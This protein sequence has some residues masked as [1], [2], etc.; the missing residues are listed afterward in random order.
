MAWFTGSL[1]SGREGAVKSSL[2]LTAVDHSKGNASGTRRIACIHSLLDAGMLPPLTV[3]PGPRATGDTII[4][5]NGS[6]TPIGFHILRK[7]SVPFVPPKPNELDSTAF[8]GMD[9]AICGT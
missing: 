3:T 7:I 6:P 9:R 2:V 5:R 4:F 8:I 1:P